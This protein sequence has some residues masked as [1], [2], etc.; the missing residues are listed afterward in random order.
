M[1]GGAQ[2][3]SQFRAYVCMY[4]CKYVCM[5]VCMYVCLYVCMY[6]CTPDLERPG[7]QPHQQGLCEA[8]LGYQDESPQLGAPGPG[9]VHTDTKAFTGMSE[10]CGHRP[11][12]CNF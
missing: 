9:L 7:R 3:T 5:Y 1:S 4:V 2:G 10:S 6:V 8:R 11:R 12:S